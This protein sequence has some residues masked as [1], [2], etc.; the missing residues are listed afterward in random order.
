MTELRSTSE[1]DF[2]SALL[3]SSDRLETLDAELWKSGKAW[4]EVLANRT[5]LKGI[6]LP[7]ELKAEGISR[8][9]LLGVDLLNWLRWSGTEPV[10]FLPVLG[11]A[12][13]SVAQILRKKPNLLLISEGTTFLRLP[14][15]AENGRKALAEFVDAVRVGKVETC[16]E[17]VLEKYATNGSE[18]VARLT[19][20]DLA[21]DYYAAE[22]LWAGYLCALRDAGDKLCAEDKKAVHAELGLAEKV[23]LECQRMVAAKKT[24]PWFKQY[25]LAAKRAELPAYP[26]IEFPHALLAKHV[27]Y[28]LP[29]N[30]RIL[31][32]DDEYEKGTAEVLLRIF[33]RTTKFTKKIDSEWVYSEEIGGPSR[34]T[35]KARLVCVKD[36]ERARY[37][38]AKWGELDI[39]E[40]QE[41][42]ELW[43]K[44][45][46]KALGW[47]HFPPTSTDPEP[48]TPL[49]LARL[50]LAP[51]TGGAEVLDNEAAAPIRMTTIVLLDLRLKKKGLG[52]MYAVR[53]LPSVRLRTEIKD[54]KPSL[55]VIMYT[56][57]RQAMNFAEIMEDAT[58]LDGW[59]C[60]EAPDIKEDD[61]NSKKA[62]QYLL[63]RIHLFA[64][65]SAWYREELQ[66]ELVEKTAYGNMID[67]EFRKVCLSYVGQKATELFEMV[68]S[69]EFANQSARCNKAF[70]GFIQERVQIPQ[71]A[72]VAPVLVARRVAVATLLLTSGVR[73]EVLEWDPLEFIGRLRGDYAR[74]RAE[75]EG[76]RYPSKAVNF[77]RECWL[78]SYEPAKLASLL[79]A[80]EVD[81]LRDQAWPRNRENIKRWVEATQSVLSK[82]TIE[83]SAVGS[84]IKRKKV[85]GPN[86]TPRALSAAE[87]RNATRSGADGKRSNAKQRGK[88]SLRRRTASQ[89]KRR[90]RE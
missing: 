3:I 46:A 8:Q 72:D 23:Q 67:S 17:E 51:G 39:E 36:T 62:F 88:T 38:L 1:Y 77:R 31:F 11:F 52:A 48:P 69:G 81:W 63:A 12:W 40:T 61:Q 58:K 76:K 64:G 25:Q 15:A 84:G 57:S 18:E 68:K 73:R 2:R 33:F 86:T 49:E 6:V 16:S 74:S 87:E 7:L 27:R 90:R 29:R 55:P 83:S 35:R 50:A 9:R 30:A 56:A 85:G 45:W 79:L 21:N 71:F 44:N 42:V 89:E 26:E 24:Q 20:H 37:W 54:Q 60:K 41:G 34:S 10:R 80:E 47:P 19:Y 75:S 22:R 43:Y 78:A 13:Q 82:S 70:L 66:W 59:L 5:D 28:G 65:A 32:V 53:N 4:T 14:E